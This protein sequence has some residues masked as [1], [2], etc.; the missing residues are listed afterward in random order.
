MIRACLRLRLRHTMLRCRH[1]LKRLNH[2]HLHLHLH[3]RL[4]HL[5]RL[6]RVRNSLSEAFSTEEGAERQQVILRY[7]TRSLLIAIDGK[8]A[9]CLPRYSHGLTRRSS[10]GDG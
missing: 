5:R 9:M 8:T 2:L 6:L 4:L 7:A 10:S 3:L 1:F